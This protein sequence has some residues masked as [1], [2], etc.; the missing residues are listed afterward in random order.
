MAKIVRTARERARQLERENML[1]K[2]E[3]EKAKATTEYI[4]MMVDVELP[5][6]EETEGN[7]N[8]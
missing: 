5:E 1:L 7:D 3:L 2:A 6:E 4:G 8:E